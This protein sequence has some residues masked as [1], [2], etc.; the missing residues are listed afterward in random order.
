MAKFLAAILLIFISYD[1]KAQ[2]WEIGGFGG[3]SGYMGDLNPNN[4]LKVSGMAAGAFLKY[5]F[6]GYLSV[7]LNYTYG[8]I[9]AADSTSADPQFKSRNLSF[10]TTLN[11]LS[12][13][14]EFNFMRYIPSVSKNI[15]TPYVFA[16][17]GIV[18][19]NPQANYMGQTYDLRLL[20]TE[21]E[22]VY[23][24][25]A[26]TVPF[27]VGFKYNFAGRLTLGTQL[28]YR[29]AFTDYLDDVSAKYPD[30]NKLP[31]ALSVALS[32]RSGEK[33]GVY[34]GTTGTQRG[35]MRPHDTYLFVGFTISYTFITAKCYY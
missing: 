30:K 25:P 17:V 12:L 3:G 34:T 1:L 18:S 32:D 33:T 2:S 14:S 24:N 6:N 19:Y 27:G 35:D 29:A 13:T 10:R 5:N 7:G 15:Y 16:G 21:G 4:P 9:R 26:V 22:A 8:V 23:A 20:Q 31:N 11:E 28:G